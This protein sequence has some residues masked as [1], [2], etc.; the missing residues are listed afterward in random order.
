ML[1]LFASSKIKRSKIKV[2]SCKIRSI[3]SVERGKQWKTC[4]ELFCAQHLIRRLQ[5]EVVSRQLTRNS[6]RSLSMRWHS[7]PAIH[8]HSIGCWCCRYWCGSLTSS[9]FLL[10]QATQRLNS[11][12]SYLSATNWLA[13][14]CV[15]V[16]QDK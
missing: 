11:H 5:N 13:A 14:I 10:S 16:T 15:L 9:T 8:R 12:A 2:A 1:L 6:L 3:Y 7:R 4:F